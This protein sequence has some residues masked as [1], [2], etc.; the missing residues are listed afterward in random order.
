LIA[1]AKAELNEFLPSQA[2]CFLYKK[3]PA[4]WQVK[5]L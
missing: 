1:G 4:M 3:G 2:E 5:S